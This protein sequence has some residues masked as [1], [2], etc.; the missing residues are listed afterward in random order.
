MNSSPLEV[1]SPA[2]DSCSPANQKNL[3][4][5]TTSAMAELC[6]ALNPSINLEVVDTILWHSAQ[7]QFETPH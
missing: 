7:G 5:S 2:L 3:P 6:G 1:I 4:N